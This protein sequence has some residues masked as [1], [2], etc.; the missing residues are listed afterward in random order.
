MFK[1]NIITQLLSFFIFAVMVNQLSLNILLS[2]SIIFSVILLLNRTSQFWHFIKRFKWLFLVMITIFSL[3]TPGEH[4]PAWPFSF[5]PTY[6]GIAAGFT[7]VLRVIVMLAA[8]SLI[9]ASNSRQQ[10]ISGF[11]FIFMPLK[12]FGLKVER[13]AV[14]LWL[15][16]HYVELQRE[17]KSPHDFFGRLKAMTAMDPYQG[18]EVSSIVF[19][20]PRFYWLDY[21]LIAFSVLLLIKLVVKAFV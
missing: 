11:Y 1:I 13:F 19:T 7:Q 17:N 3:N 21:G 20:I 18:N 5:V 2:V 12:I 16:L 8:I 15:T 9:V 14:R 4:I 10:L 6:E